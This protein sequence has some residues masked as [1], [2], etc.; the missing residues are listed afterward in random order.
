MN[1]KLIWSLI[2]IVVIIV[3]VLFASQNNSRPQTV[4]AP[5]KI[6]AVISLTGDAA[7]WGGYA[8]NGMDLAVNEINAGGGID[9]RKV[10]VVYEDDHTD[11]KQGVSAFNKL[12][13]IDHVEGIIGGVFDFTAQPLIPLALN[14]KVA[15]ISPS[16]FRIAGGF[17]LNEQSFVMRTDFNQTVEKI[18]PFIA[19]SS[20]KKL[21]V[22]HFKSTFGGEIAKTLDGVMKGLGRQGIIDEPYDKIGN[23][24]FKT[25]IIKL[26]SAGVDGV[27][28]DMVANDPLIFLKQAKQ[29]G[30]SPSIITYNGLTDAFSNETDKSPMNGV[31]ILNWEIASPQFNDMYEKAYGIPATKSADRYFDAVYVMAEGIAKADSLL[32][33]SG[34]EHQRVAP[35]IEK[36]AFFTPNSSAII[37][38]PE[39]S[40]KN[41]DVMI[42]VIKNGAAVPWVK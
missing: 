17:D 29:L 24:D 21:A 4:N 1:K 27:F 13:S 23:N 33:T 20:I 34:F 28:L 12:V 3:I 37:F 22:V 2:V 31:I 10:E 36:T 15:F 41:T 7:P 35:Y 30:F 11:P 18:E 42:Q 14:E 26:K 32:P 19:S 39:H 40:V 25:T 6:G 9:G 16:N 38:T 8:K 5:I